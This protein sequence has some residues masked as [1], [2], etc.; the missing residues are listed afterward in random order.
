MLADIDFRHPIFAPFADPRFNDFTRIHFWKYRRLDITSVPGAREVAKFDSGAPALLEVPVGK[1]RLLVLTSGWQP[2]DSQLA[3]STK[4]VPLLFSILEASG[5][6]LPAPTQYYVGEPVPLAGA[7]GAGSAALSVRL[8]D[9][10]QVDLPAGATNFSQSTMPGIYT[11][12]SAQPVRRFAVNLDPTE[13]RTAALAPDELERLSAPL[14]HPVGLVA[15]EAAQKL[16]LQ[17][18]ELESRQKLWRWFVLMTLAV[19]L[20]ETWAA[21]RAGRKPAALTGGATL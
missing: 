7:S 9:G 14:A 16:R 18:T 4:F 6:P 19:L 15:R 2:E 20:F 10:S 1:G 11:I 12:A 13:S 8:P 5:A 21:G 3:L 17:N